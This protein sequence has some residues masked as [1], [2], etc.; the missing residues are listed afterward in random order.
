MKSKNIFE[1][2]IAVLIAVSVLPVFSANAEDGTVL[3]SVTLQNFDFSSENQTT[4]DENAKDIPVLYGAA[5]YSEEYGNVRLNHKN[6][7]SGIRLALSEPVTAQT[8]ENTVT[9]EFDLNIGSGSGLYYT[10]SVS[11]SGGT[12]IAEMKFTPYSDSYDGA[13]L[14]IG[15]KDVIAAA[16]ETV[17]KQLKN[18]MSYATKDGMETEP[19]HFKHEINLAGGTASV[20]ISSGSKSGTFT[21]TIGAEDIAVIDMSVNKVNHSRYIYADNIKLTQMRR[22]EPAPVDEL[23]HRIIVPAEGVTTV[24]DTSKLVYG[25]HV[26][27]MKVITSSAG[28]LVNSCVTASDMSVEVD[29]AGAD[30][31]E[32]VPVYEY[33]G[34][35][36][37][38]F[39]ST[40]GAELENPNAI[41]CFEDGRYDI[42]IQKADGK[43]TDIYING[44]MV[45][46][47]IEQPG[48]GRGNPKG[49]LYTAKDIKIAGGKIRINTQRDEYNGTTYP[50]APISSVTIT[51][52]PKTVERKTKIT[53]LGDSLTAEYYEGRREADLGSN[54]TG[55]GQQLANFTDADKYNIVNLANSGHYAKILYETAMDGAVANSLEGDIILV[56]AGYND[57]VRSNETEMAEYMDKMINAAKSAGLNIIFV[58]PPATTDDETKYDSGYKNPID[59]AAPDYVNTSYS[60]PARYGDIVKETAKNLGAGFIDLSR[61]SYDYLT[62]LYGFDIDTARELYMQSFGVSDGIHLSWAGAMK[63][64]SF[65]AQSLYDSGYIDSINSEFDY[66]VTDFD[67]NSIIC[68]VYEDGAHNDID[69]TF[70]FYDVF[71]TLNTIGITTKVQAEDKVYAALYRGDGTLIAVKSCECGGAEQTLEFDLPQERG[72]YMKVFN[73]DENMRPVW[74]NGK[75]IYADDIEL[76]IPDSVLAGKTVYAFGDSIVY[77]HNAPSK[78]FMKLIEGDYDM[79]LEMYAKNGASVVNAD[80]SEKEDENEEKTGNYIINQVRNASEAPPDI[81]IFDGYTNDAYGDPAVDKEFNSN[82]AHID[83]M[84]NLG[85]ISGKDASDFDSSTFCGA[86][87]EIIYEMKQKWPDVPI[88]FVTI[89]KSGGRNWDIQCRLRELAVE[90]CD[91]WGVA[92]A[93]VFDDTTLDTRDAGQMK[94]YIINGAGSHPK[95]NACR[96]F[97][98]PVVTKAMKKSLVT[99]PSKLPENINDTVDIVLFS[100]QSNMS[101]RGSASEAAAC[102]KNAGFEYKSISDPNTLNPITEPF[103]LNE[104]REG[105]LTDKNSDGSTK[106]S[107]SMVSAFVNEYYKNTGRQ[108]VAVSASMGGTSSGEWKNK[109]ADDAAARLDAAKEFLLRNGINIGRVF[110]VWCQ[111]ETDGDN[112]VSAETYTE[113]TM[114]IFDKF[115]AHGAEHIFMIGTGHFNYIKYPSESGTDKRYGIIRDAQTAMCEQ[116]GGTVTMAASFESYID[117]MT[118]RYHYNQAAYDEIGAAAARSAAEYFM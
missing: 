107:G 28:E 13:Y 16:G 38:I 36:T 67:G 61:Y 34:L 64:A 101:G 78:S 89:H 63:W 71:K 12:P 86:F 27:M 102:D 21:G 111:G 77:G 8:N 44:K 115:I 73:W 32:I 50:N 53:I 90:I 18:C 10:Y 79:T 4:N 3:R 5:E 84:Q 31:V 46:N 15:G 98:I 96:E 48:K 74:E 94:E 114:E 57:R 47:N 40:D 29:T 39:N 88:V 99:A 20:T 60:Y 93:D 110:V 30:T 70:K 58:S 68:R 49:S 55:W 23:V 118:D 87:E 80:S 2:I 37:V 92:V 14:R 19:T 24:V 62:S 65:V 17:N 42:A 1:W 103:G 113:N 81:I 22:I 75:T 7:A 56:Q 33:T 112:N 59:T 41:G 45:G 26:S 105:G 66:T 72:T 91:E 9:F 108:I 11:G 43:L 76:D 54:Q 52:L 106:R 35:E 95:E 82:G 109:Y 25:G 97:Y 51:P 83:I 6:G 69:K 100:G 85:T 104:D 116:S 117:N